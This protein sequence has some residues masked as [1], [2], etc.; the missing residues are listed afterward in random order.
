MAACSAKPQ[1][2]R[3]AAETKESPSS[4]AGIEWVS[5]PGGV[6]KMGIGW[7]KHRV[8]VSAFQMARTEVTNRQYRACMAAGACTQ[9]NA[10]GA[11]FNDEDHPVVGVDWSQAQAF[12]RWAG[13]RLPTEAQWEYAARSAGRPWKF[14]W[15]DEKATRARAVMDDGGPG[16]GRN[17]SWPVC[18]K[19]EG[20]TAQGLC[21]MAG[22][23]WE[24]TQ[25]WYHESFSGAP[26]DGSARESPAGAYRVI[27]GG[28]WFD[29]AGYA[30]V[31]DRGSWPEHRSDYVGFRLARPP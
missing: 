10:A 18:S 15:G 6:F 30:R 28:S 27:R 2:R 19:P 21:D 25:D 3:D 12:S 4:P 17:S 1:S 20:N 14:P 16:C 7:K 11:R 9:P 5:L 29:T 13:G 24:W 31:A 8:T 22:N 23:A 26:T